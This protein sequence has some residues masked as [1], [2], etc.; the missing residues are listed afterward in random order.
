MTSRKERKQEKISKRHQNP[1][2]FGTDILIGKIEGNNTIGLVTSRNGKDVSIEFVRDDGDPLQFEKPALLK[3]LPCI[4]KELHFLIADGWKAVQNYLSIL[5]LL[6]RLVN[7]EET[8]LMEIGKMIKAYSFPHPQI[9][10]RQALS[11]VSLYTPLPP[12]F[13]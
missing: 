12:V 7:K 8:L 10:K 11:F 6:D 1:D 9:L 4:G 3:K 5:M 13:H 2:P